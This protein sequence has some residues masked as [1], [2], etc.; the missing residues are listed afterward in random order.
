MRFG[1]LIAAIRTA[2]PSVLA[3][4]VGGVALLA[5][6][7]FV[8][9]AADSHFRW[10]SHEYLA[11]ARSLASGDGFSMNGVADA[12]RTPGYPVFLLLFAPFVF[13]PT[14]IAIAQH[15]LAVALVVALFFAVRTLTRDSL[16]AFIAAGLVAID[17][18]QIYMAHKVMTESIMAIAL[19][20]AIFALARAS[21][22]QSVRLVAI[23][24]LMTSI[25]VLIRPAAM[26]L[27]IPVAVWIGVFFARRRIAAVAI[28][29][30]CAVIPPAAWMWR[31]YEKAGIATLSSLEGENL[32]YYR[33]AAV[34]AIAR[35]GFQYSPLP[36]VGEKEFHREFFRVAQREFIVDSRRAI[37][38][39][40]GSSATNLSQADISKFNRGLAIQIFREYPRESMLLALYGALHLMFD[41]T[42][43]YAA[44]IGGGLI[45]MPL[46]CILLAVSIASL[47]LSIAGFRRLRRTEPAIAW[48]L[49]VTLV[50]FVVVLS[51]AEHE[52]WRYR[53]PLIPVYSILIACAALRPTSDSR[54]V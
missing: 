13:D 29:V 9:F 4:V 40:F 46:I 33:A 16:V 1:R 51:G 35:T 17:T 50:Y 15:A 14:V 41:G 5:H 36:F 2:R 30:A 31:N 47:V 25:A 42:W 37:E 18:G 20:A 27:W 44:V 48:L 52:Q 21:T 45:R 34:V 38:Q 24:G 8:L 54:S 28:F 12:R 39:R 3:A 53:I 7:H 43:E 11:L 32:Y 6:L 10:D 19:V 22:L 23:G 26:Y 49:A